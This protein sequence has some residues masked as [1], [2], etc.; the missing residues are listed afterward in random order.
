VAFAIDVL[1]AWPKT[2]PGG[3]ASGF[4]PYTGPLAASQTVL[5]YA[6]NNGSGVSDGSP[7]AVLVEVKRAIQCL[8]TGVQ[9]SNSCDTY[10]P[11]ITAPNLGGVFAWI[12]NY[13]A[14]NDYQF[15]KGIYPC[16]VRGNCM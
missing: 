13:D 5:G 9:G 11:P 6:V 12:I 7:A 8:R 15:G 1:T 10:I 16:V 2:C 14:S 4:Q 3:Q